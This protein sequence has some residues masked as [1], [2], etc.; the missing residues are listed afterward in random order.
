[1]DHI[2]KIANKA[3]RNEQPQQEKNGSAI[4]DKTIINLWE[5]MNHIYGHKFSATYG[6]SAVKGNE[7]T[8]TARTWQTGLRGVTGEQIAAGLHECIDCGE[9]WPPALPE[10]VKMCR[11]KRVNEFGID[12]I[13][14]YHREVNRVSP[15]NRLSSTERDAHRKEV[16]SKGMADLKSALKGEMK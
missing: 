8:A 16:S 11:G 7:L 9:S 10:F 12:Y 5:R 6:E 3:L 4:T 13:P 14:E 15:E 2:S 1:M